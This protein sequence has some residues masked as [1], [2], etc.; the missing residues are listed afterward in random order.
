MSILEQT[1]AICKANNIKPA[2]SKG[3]NFLIV[4]EVYDKII[5]AAELKKTDKVLEIGPGLG[6]LTQKLSENSGQVTAVELDEKLGN[7]LK[8]S[9][10]SA[11]N[12]NVTIMQGNALDLQTSPGNYKIVAN[13]PYNI[14]SAFLRKF[15]SQAK[16][17]PEL[18]VLLVQKEV[19]ER[20][21]AKPGA[22]SLL[23]ISVQVYAG[24]EIIDFVPAKA[25]YPAPEVES[26]IIRLRVKKK[27]S[28]NFDEKIYFQLVRIGF[29]A[30]RKKLANNLAA[31]FQI[32]AKE[33]VDWLK[34]AG[35][36]ETI[37][38][39]ELAVKDWEKLLKEKS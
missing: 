36:A 15:L 1:H 25:F 20:L 39:Q 9:K 23:A 29:S 37:R 5:E 2:K 33:A 18:M 17:P 19:A 38:A 26:A 34:R 28:D 6:F 3:Q 8:S 7:I 21:C 10:F 11:K 22:M 12:S 32:T 13:L 35:F 30:R 24:A 31:G 27:S 4:E 14:T 16:Q